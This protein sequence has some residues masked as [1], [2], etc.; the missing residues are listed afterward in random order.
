MHCTR[1]DYIA[2]LSCPRRRMESDGVTFTWV[3]SSAYCA[4]LSMRHPNSWKS[5]TCRLQ[6]RRIL[7]SGPL[8]AFAQNCN[9]TFVFLFTQTHPFPAVSSVAKHKKIS[10][11]ALPPKFTGEKRRPPGGNS[12]SRHSALKALQWHSTG[13]RATG[14]TACTPTKTLHNHSPSQDTAGALCS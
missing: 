12:G 13:H 1:T 9:I 5:I 2:S 14:I 3:R 8:H 6:C 10:G 11:C 4:S 7:R